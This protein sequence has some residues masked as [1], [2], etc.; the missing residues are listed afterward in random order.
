MQSKGRAIG[1]RHGRPVFG[2]RAK[3]H[4]LIGDSN[5]TF[6]AILAVTLAVEIMLYA[7]QQVRA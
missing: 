3:R 4:H 5:M 6:A 2:T 1:F 7:A